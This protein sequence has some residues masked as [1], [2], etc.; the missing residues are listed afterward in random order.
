MSFSS[1]R[2]LTLIF[3][4]IGVLYLSLMIVRPDEL[5]RLYWEQSGRLLGRPYV[6]GYVE[7]VQRRVGSAPPAPDQ[8]IQPPKRLAPYTEFQSEY[9]P[10]SLWSFSLVRLF[11]EN[12]VIFGKVFGF[13]MAGCIAIATLAIYYCFPPEGRLGIASVV[14]AAGFAGW[15][16]LVGS[17]TVSRFDSLAMLA[18]GLGLWAYSRSSNLWSAVCFGLGGSVKIWPLLLLPALLLTPSWKSG[19]R[20]V[21]IQTASKILMTGF[22]AFM[23]PHVI[24]LMLGTSPSDLFGYLSYMSERPLQIESMAGNLVAIWHF[25]TGAEVTAKFDFGSSNIMI[26]G[27]KAFAFVIT[28]IYVIA[29]LIILRIVAM[30][31][32]DF[33]SFAYSCGLIIITTILCS[34][35]FSGEYLIWLYPTFIVSILLRNWGIAISYIAFLLALKV[36]YWNFMSVTAIEPLGTA[37]VFLKNMLGIVLAITLARSLLPKRDYYPQ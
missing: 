19:E 24:F 28:L 21:S 16:I 23:I 34:K 4:V 14:C 3:A 15:V 12:H 5:N 32:G 35:V 2:L 6:N 29:Y 25:V 26:D 13:L 36:V 27:W 33:S 8:A 17:F 22:A 30:S 37:L 31:R 18:A 9:P 1:N 20:H 7:W 11:F 10:G